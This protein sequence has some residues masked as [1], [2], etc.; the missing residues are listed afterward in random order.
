MATRPLKNYL[1]TYRRKA[2]LSQEEMAFL[3]GRKHKA[4]FSRY[5]KYRCVPPLQMALACEALFRVPASK[6]FAGISDATTREIDGR[7]DAL[8]ARLEGRK[9]E[10]KYKPL[11]QRKLAWIQERAGRSLFPTR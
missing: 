6:L 1:R 10:G 5:E 8:K 7:I 2:G 4:Q 9:A 3:L 11:I